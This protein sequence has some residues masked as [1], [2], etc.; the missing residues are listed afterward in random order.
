MLILEIILTIFAWRKGWRWLALLPM[1]I[2]LL[3]GF[4]IGIG[5]GANGGDPSSV[6]FGAVFIDI[7][8]I[9]ALII[10]VATKPKSAEVKENET[11][12]V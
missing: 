6:G 5:I 10:M 1:G 3:V 2:A 11:P 8:A 4:S 9:I 12:K 7:I